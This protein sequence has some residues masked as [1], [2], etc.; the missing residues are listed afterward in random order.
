MS[1]DLKPIW[2]YAFKIFTKNL[3]IDFKSLSLH[4]TL[5]LFRVYLLSSFYIRQGSLGRGPC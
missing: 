1:N 5:E 3:H 4:Q 2:E